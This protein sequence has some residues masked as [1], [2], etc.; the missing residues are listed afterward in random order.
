MVVRELQIALLLK[1][2]LCGTANLSYVKQMSL[3]FPT[4]IFF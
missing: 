1:F 4:E 3:S 2:G